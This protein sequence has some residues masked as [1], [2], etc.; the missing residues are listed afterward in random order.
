MRI[1]T[2]LS[3]DP[4][5]ASLNTKAHALEHCAIDRDSLGVL[6]TAVGRQVLIRRTSKRLALYTVAELIDAA[7]AAVHVGTAGLARLEGVTG[8]PPSGGLPATVQTDFTQGDPQASVRLTEELLGDPASGLAVLAP[9]GGLIEVGTDDQARAVYD[10][11]ALEA[12]RV[13]AWIAQGFNPTIGAHRCWHITSSEISEQSFP[14]LGALFDPGASR[15]SFAHAVAFH[16]QNDTAAVVIGGGLPRDEAHT[17]L[18]M[19]LRSRV[20][21]AL[22]AV[23][24]P[25]PA[26]VVRRSGPLAGAQRRNI[27]NRVTARGNG[28]QLEQPAGVRNDEQQ[29]EAIAQAVAAFYADLI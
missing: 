22:R 12:K 15:G 19:T 6:A 14:R 4:K 8:E 13:R 16:G 29:R 27:V 28:I 17:A 1:P 10:L 5:S 23:V 25:P 7:G 11:L 24:D 21:D 20:Q 3:E 26:V 9:H 2:C 18:K